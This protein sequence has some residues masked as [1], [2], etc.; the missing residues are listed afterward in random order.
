MG[1]E[2]LNEEDLAYILDGLHQLRTGYSESTTLKAFQRMQQLEDDVR[3]KC[4]PQ[5]VAMVKEALRKIVE[6][7]ML[8]KELTR[9]IRIFL[10]AKNVYF[11][12][13]DEDNNEHLQRMNNLLDRTIAELKKK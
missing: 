8:S 7:S 9:D 12:F 2:Q 5:Y 1:K 4:Q 11:H 3:Y 10:I 6:H 13:G